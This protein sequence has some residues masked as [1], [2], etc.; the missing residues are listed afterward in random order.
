MRRMTLNPN[1][2]LLVVSPVNKYK[3]VGPGRVWITPR[4][5]IISKIYVGT[6]GR[7][8]EFDDVRPAEDLSM[9]MKVQVVYQVDP[10]LFTEQL[11]P[12]IEWL[13]D[14]GWQNVLQWQVEYVLRTLVGQ[15]PWRN[16]KRE[17]IKQRLERRLA[18]T[19]ADRVKIMGLNILAFCLVKIEL[20]DN[21][22]RTLTRA[23]QDMAEA[24][25]RLEVLK[26]YREV[27]GESMHQAMPYII[28]WEMLNTIHKNDPQILLSAATPPPDALTPGP[29]YQLQLPVSPRME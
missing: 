20:P 21:L 3:V 17:E 6:Q 7:S 14:G 2:R 29:V 27:F 12:K 1:E 10:E 24:Q 9:K 22:Q 8:L 28:Q 18:Q 16:L 23:E 19:L 4:Q 11:L 15:H 25:G 13:N 5:K 26:G